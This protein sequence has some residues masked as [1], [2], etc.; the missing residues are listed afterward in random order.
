MSIPESGMQ[1]RTV[2]QIV[3]PDGTPYEASRTENIWLTHAFSGVADNN[4]VTPYF[5]GKTYFADLIEAFASATESIYIAGWQVNWDAQLAPEVRLYDCLL[6]AA[7]RGVKIYVMPWDD[8]APV[9]TYDEQTRAVLL[10]INRQV[11]A[12]QVFVTL[13]GSR[14]DAAKA[15]FSHHQKQVVIDQRIGF[16]GGLD[17]AYGRYDDETYDLRA[18]AD[19]RQGMNRYNGCVPQLGHLGWANLINPDQK[20][21]RI[22]KHHYQT[23]YDADSPGKVTDLTPNS[24]GPRRLLPATHALAGHPPAHRRPGGLPPDTQLCFALERP[25]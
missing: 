19:G 10:D 18:D 14:A 12:E 6:A 24:A 5:T 3:D 23:P 7:Q 15:F 25:A 21:F 4:A 2:C 9:Q 8:S 17:L 1:Q 11:G 16:V 20:D 13:A 22:E